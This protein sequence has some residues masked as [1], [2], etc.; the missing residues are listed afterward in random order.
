[1]TGIAG[2]MA[3]E[4]LDRSDERDLYMRRI[5]QAWRDGWQR[6][7]EDG[8]A[9]GRQDEAADRGRAWNKIARAAVKGP[10]HAELERRRWM[11]RGEPR[12]RADFADP[13][14]GDYPGSRKGA[15]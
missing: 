1:M 13:H 2:Q 11:V 15:A 9:R 7:D 4:L 6:G 10:T 14:P 5:E 12:T 3:A 8:Y